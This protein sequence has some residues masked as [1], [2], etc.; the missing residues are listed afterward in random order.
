MLSITDHI[1]QDFKF[2]DSIV[3]RGDELISWGVHVEELDNTNK[4]QFYSNTH[5]VRLTSTDYNC[6]SYSIEASCFVFQ[7][8]IIGSM[9][10]LSEEKQFWTRYYS[11]FPYSPK[12]I[13][14]L[15]P[16]VYYDCHAYHLEVKSEP[17]AIDLITRLRLTYV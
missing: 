1:F 2:W 13:I 14:E 17:D 12:N 16:G 7:Y 11:E 15:Y 5:K 10:S 3:D 9:L 6:F 8:E 4:Y